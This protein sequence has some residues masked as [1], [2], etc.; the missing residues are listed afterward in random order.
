MDFWERA[1]VAMSCFR[2]CSQLRLTLENEGDCGCRRVISPPPSCRRAAS[3]WWHESAGWQVIRSESVL[4]RKAPALSSTATPTRN[5]GRGRRTRSLHCTN[6]LPCMKSKTIP[7]LTCLSRKG[8][9][10]LVVLDIWT[11]T[12]IMIMM[13]GYY[14]AFG[15]KELSFS[16]YLQFFRCPLSEKHDHHVRF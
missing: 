4:T 13:A 3:V 12:E 11:M 5:N 10:S 14:G 7:Q 16:V 1:G 15:G 6:C 2:F 9:V 8:N